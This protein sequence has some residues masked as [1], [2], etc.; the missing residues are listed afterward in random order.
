MSPLRCP[1]CDLPLEG[2]ACVVAGRA[3]SLSG[4]TCGGAWFTWLQL[5]QVLGGEVALEPLSAQTARRCPTCTLSLTPV[6]LPGVIPVETC[7][8][9]RGVWLDWPDVLDLRL[10]GLEA[11]LQPAP[12]QRYAG[13]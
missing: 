11:V 12:A 7:S 2:R 1:D 4:C 10:P 13:L 3:G 9:C 5:E 8:A 6:L